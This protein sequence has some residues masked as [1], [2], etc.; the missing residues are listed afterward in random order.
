[1]DTRQVA[2]ASEKPLRFSASGVS[3]AGKVNRGVVDRLA[4]APGAGM[5]ED[6][7]FSSEQGVSPHAGP[8][9]GLGLDENVAGRSGVQ[10][11]LFHLDPALGRRAVAAD[12]RAAGAGGND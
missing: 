6:H 7:S 1:V 12:T 2:R 10:G 4:T 5:D 8:A 3:H 11:A 9:Q